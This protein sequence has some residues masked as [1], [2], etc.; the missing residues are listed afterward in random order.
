MTYKVAIIGEQELRNRASFER[1]LTK[2]VK[3]YILRH[4]YVIF[5]VGAN[6]ATDIA[7]LHAVKAAK[8]MTQKDNCKII[9]LMPDNLN[10]MEYTKIPFDGYEYVSNITDNPWLMPYDMAIALT[11]AAHVTVC[12]GNNPNGYYKRIAT[13][14]PK[15]VYI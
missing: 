3:Y 5:Y 7:A 13:L 4:E 12:N 15:I 14:A 1:K 11:H 8:E 6:P 9:A 10:D 2:V